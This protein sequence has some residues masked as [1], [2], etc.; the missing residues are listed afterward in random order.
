MILTFF[1]LLRKKKYF[2][3]W[4]AYISK[5]SSMFSVHRM[6]WGTFSW[7][8]LWCLLL[9]HYHA[10]QLFWKPKP[11]CLTLLRTL[12]FTIINISLKRNV[13]HFFFLASGNSSLRNLSVLIWV[14]MSSVKERGGSTCKSVT[15]K[16]KALIIYILLKK[17]FP[18]ETYLFVTRKMCEMASS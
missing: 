1:L 9:I 4:Y 2:R 17:H 7:D 10:D 3:L 6:C 8:P 15:L 14:I 16:F 11:T 13:A 5:A 18:L 12:L